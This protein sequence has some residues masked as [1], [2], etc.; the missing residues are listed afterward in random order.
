VK[1]SDRRP[2]DCGGALIRLNQTTTMKLHLGCFN[3]PR[4]GWHNTD[5]TPHIFVSRIPLAAR[6]L[7]AAGK[8]TAARFEEHQVG[9]FKRVH[10]LN[11]S[12]NFPFADNSVDAVFSSHIIEHLTE[13]VARHMLQESLRVLK[14]GGVCRTVA[15]SLNWALS[16]YDEA[17][18][19][20]ML[21]AILE[22]DHSNP[23]NR[24]QW[25]YTAPSLC[26][27]KRSVGFVDVREFGYRE[28]RLPD[29]EAL[30]N[31][32]ENSIYVEGIK[33]EQGGK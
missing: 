27:L 25:M 14:P 13:S 17:Q 21:D 10:Y 23:K 6:L 2:R 19:E 4:E 12:K 3:Q 11:V 16:L 9:I 29:L 30:D 22:Q 1:L 15:P 28:G 32:P 24:H 18:P 20:K 31:R 33:G 7:K 26:R 5:I 8:M